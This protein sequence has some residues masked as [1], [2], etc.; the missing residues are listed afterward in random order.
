MLEKACTRNVSRATCSYYV[1]FFSMYTLQYITFPSPLLELFTFTFLV[2]FPGLIS[3]QFELEYK[4]F[5]KSF[6]V[7]VPDVTELTRISYI[8]IPPLPFFAS[9]ALS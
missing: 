5:A 9:D 8:R 2:F 7:F 6:F 4:Y 3:R 1:H